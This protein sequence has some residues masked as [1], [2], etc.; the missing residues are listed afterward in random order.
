MPTGSG[1]PHF[2]ASLATHSPYPGQGIYVGGKLFQQLQQASRISVA[3][4]N[5]HH[6]PG[7]TV[8]AHVITLPNGPQHPIAVDPNIGVDDFRY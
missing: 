1:L 5:L 3:T 6:I 4:G 8:H 7:A 2:N